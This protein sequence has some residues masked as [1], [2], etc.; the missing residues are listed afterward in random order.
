V[1][2]SCIFC[3]AD[4]GS[5]DS[6]GRFPVGRILAVDGEKGRL[7]AVCAKC[8]RW[9]LAPIHERWEAI[10]EAE[11]L[12]HDTRVRAQG[13]SIGLCRLRDGTRLVRVGQAPPGEL[14]AWRYGRTML[15]RYQGLRAT[16]RV[17]RGLGVGLG[18]G[19]PAAMGVSMATGHAGPAVAL[20]L[21]GV[22]V[23]VWGRARPRRRFRPLLPRTGVAVDA[24]DLQTARFAL[25]SGGDVSVALSGYGE[26]DVRRVD[27]ELR[28]GWLIPSADHARVLLRR[29][30]VRLNS[31]GAPE[32]GVGTAMGLLTEHGSGTELLRRAAVDRARVADGSVYLRVRSPRMLAVEMAVHDEMERRALDG[33]LAALTEA[34]RQAEEVAAIADRLPHADPRLLQEG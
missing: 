2:R 4:L 22:V 5:N 15:R 20:C 6:I 26:E 12:F 7:W 18:A 24:G 14:A 23:S 9:N 3:S 29:G 31:V 13:E 16:E 1:Y 28:D 34:W 8:A 21:A 33:D 19:I 11:R 10:E 32:H 27:G 30:M 25:T 17:G